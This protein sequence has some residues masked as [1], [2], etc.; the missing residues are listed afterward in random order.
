MTNVYRVS[1]FN[2]KDGEDKRLF[3]VLITFE[4][5]YTLFK[6][7]SATNE[8][9]IRVYYNGWSTLTFYDGNW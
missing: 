4:D 1:G 8:S 2:K 5:G 6:Y 3:S 9:K 7:S